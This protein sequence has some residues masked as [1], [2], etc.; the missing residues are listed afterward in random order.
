MNFSCNCHSG[1]AL[2]YQC[3]LHC[4]LRTLPHF[5]HFRSHQSNL[6]TGQ[7][8]VLFPV[9][10]CADLPAKQKP[11]VLPHLSPPASSPAT[12]VVSGSSFKPCSVCRSALCSWSRL[13]VL[14]AAAGA[15]GCGE[16]GQCLVHLCHDYFS[17]HWE[18]WNAAGD[19]LAFPHRQPGPERFPWKKLALNFKCQC[20]NCHLFVTKYIANA[21][22][23]LFCVLGLKCSLFLNW[24]WWRTFFHQPVC[25]AMAEQPEE[26]RM[27]CSLWVTAM[28]T[29]ALLGTK[30]QW[31]KW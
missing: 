6:C 20:R 29:G 26:K 1:T 25:R 21:P 17:A 7:P 13:P 12:L 4:C 24:L 28:P 11:C 10:C 18:L 23:N 30:I 19:D 3:N 9:P 16:Q 31:G 15:W 14:G 27:W 5:K 2:A 22:V 8:S